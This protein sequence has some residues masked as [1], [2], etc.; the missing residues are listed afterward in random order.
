MPLRRAK[1]IDSLYSEV[2]DYGL[3]LT[4]DAPLALALNRRIDRPRLGFF[5]ATP[6]ML[7]SGKMRPRDDRDLFLQLVNETDLSWKRVSHL[8]ENVLGSWEET[9]EIES[10]LSFDKFD[11]EAT[12]EA[13]RLIG[14]AESTHRD[15]ARY[16]IDEDLD[17]AVIGEDWFTE[18][19]STILP[20]SYDA[21]DPFTK[22][23]FGPPEFQVFDSF[24]AIVNTV[25][26]NVSKENAEDVGVVLE[27][28]SIYRPSMESALESAGI[29]FH[30]GAGLFEDTGARTFLRLLRAGLNYRGLRLG[31]V[32]P[33]L[34]SLG[35][36]P[37]V[38][39]EE[40]LLRELDAEELGPVKQ[41]CET[42]EEQSF[43]EAL[44]SFRDL[45]GEVP[46][47]LEEEMQLL[48]VLGEKVSE[49]SLN[50]LEYYLQTVEVPMRREREGVLLADAKSDPYVDRSL[51]FFLGMDSS[52]TR[53]VLDRPW[54]DKAAKDQEYL[55]RFQVMLQSGQERYF[56]VK[57]TELGKP[58]TPCLY[59][60]ELIEEDF[61]RFTDLPHTRH[62]GRF[63]AERRGFEKETVDVET[64]RVE[65]LSQSKLNTLVNCP[66][67]YY[68]DRLVDG[69]EKHYFT[70]GTLFHDFAEFLVNHPEVVE[71]EGVNAFVE[72]MVEEMRPFVPEHELP[73]LRTE[74]LI[75]IRNIEEFLRLN[76]PQPVETDGY[77]KKWP[78]NLFG[79]KYGVPMESRVTEQWFEDPE[80]GVRGVVDLLH[81][82][83]SL[84]DYKSGRKKSPFKVVSGADM[85][86]VSEE[87][88]FQALFYIAYHRKQKPDERI[89]FTFFHFLENR[90]EAV[91]GEGDLEDTLTTVTYYPE[92]FSE[93]AG[94]REAF[95][96]LCEGVSKSNDRRK[97][98]EKLGFEAYHEFLHGKE[99]PDVGSKDEL[100]ETEF[101]GDF[102]NH[103]KRVVGDYKYVEEG[104]RSAL[105]KLFELRARNFFRDEV[106]RFEDFLQEQVENLNRYLE[107]RFPVGEPNVDRLNNRDLILTNE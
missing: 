100:L 95:E 79:E 27:S 10:I 50:G 3:V 105:K 14:E 36:S 82:P 4:T 56:L 13:V 60:H 18:L 43:R 67:D 8:I 83:G 16:S 45:G 94:G 32:K 64:R 33:V 90:N 24:N 87:P 78:G 58:V 7:A 22:G 106:D 98:L 75:G 35:V 51:V 72:T 88:D 39:D 74:F 84:L 76:P 17:V 34:T 49:G 66:R 26:E 93:F 6:R 99:F 25:M 73:L 47:E 52:W 59:L 104:S 9:G 31:E 48:G 101:A 11:D 91:T 44:R 46:G 21:V 53:S 86:P 2:Q 89:E 23:E 29:P 80:L 15:L 37:G 12:R 102:E 5:A 62:R 65:T 54:V 107:T 40:K 19:D 57:D 103:C 71:S 20:E 69:P 92:T 1:S 77:G 85:E 81:G 55:E 70:K 96:S 61:E 30:G 68:F 63:R 97:T 42:V 38:K 41:F 28:G